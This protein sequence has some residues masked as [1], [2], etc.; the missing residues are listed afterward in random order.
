MAA[1]CILELH[2]WR[3]GADEAAQTLAVSVNGQ[4]LADVE[5]APDGVARFVMPDQL[6]PSPSEI[7]IYAW[8]LLK[9]AD[10]MGSDDERTLGVWLSRVRLAGAGEGGDPHE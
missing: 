3:L 1:G 4:M 9:P 7:T 10:V 6:A 2:H 5:G 8:P